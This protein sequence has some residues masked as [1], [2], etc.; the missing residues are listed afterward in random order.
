M[1]S[2]LV[3]K[4]LIKH[5]QTFIDDG[6]ATIEKYTFN[7]TYER[8]IIGKVVVVKTGNKCQLELPVDINSSYMNPWYK[9]VG[10]YFVKDLKQTQGE[11]IFELITKTD[12]SLLY[13]IPQEL[14]EETKDK[15]LSHLKIGDFYY[16]II[17]S[18][19]IKEMYSTY[20]CDT[21]DE[22]FESTNENSFEESN[23]IPEEDLISSNNPELESIILF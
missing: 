10:N 9:D 14:F 15:E 16:M 2:N 8:F 6:A 23:I 12:K 11:N 19:P 20:R 17:K 7:D 3:S 5:L 1:T 21:A 13:K 18:I 22:K 4:E